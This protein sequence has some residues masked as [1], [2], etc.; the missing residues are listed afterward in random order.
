MA[1]VINTNS[2]AT[3]A[4]I[5]FSA[6]NDMLKKS[7]ARLSSGSRII[8]PADDAGGLAVSMKMSAAVKRTEAVQANIGNAVSYLQ[9]QD[10]ALKTM[11]KILDRMSEL[12][13]LYNDV[14]KSDA[15]KSN[16]QTEFG[17]LQS[18]L[19][20]TAKEQFNGVSL[21][22]TTT[23]DTL[24]VKV[25]EDGT[26]TVDIDQSY[27]ADAT[28]DF[29]DIQSSSNTLT[30]G[31]SVAGI[32]AAIEEIATFRAQNG[33]STNRLEFAND[34]LTVNKANLETANSRIIDVD[35]AAESTAYA[36]Y[37][38]LVQSGASMLAQANS[39]AQIAL[40]L[41]Q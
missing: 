2:A 15:D 20:A 33:A 11:G 14:T 6:S 36:R 18:Q 13:T 37:N 1:V 9:T 10:G 34:V 29:A 16:Y 23:T 17:E 19:V 32:K 26:R 31:V 28:S 30:S 27:L 25:S 7:L 40:R 35:V 8:N 21:F 12:A 3:S 22:G 39:S 5:N 38:I 4:A 41:I 24:S